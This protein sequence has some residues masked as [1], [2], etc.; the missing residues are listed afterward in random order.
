MRGT[1]DGYN[2]SRIV[3]II[4]QNKLCI[5]M[6][7]LIVYFVIMLGVCFWCGWDWEK[8]YYI[9]QIISGLFVVGGLVVSIL[10]YTASNIANT[11]LRN[12]ERKIRAAEMAN[13]FQKDLIPLMRIIS[14]AYTDS[15]L[16]TTIL[17]K[18]NNAELVMFNKQEI[19]SI[20]SE[21]EKQEMLL[22]LHSAYLAR[23]YVPTK[24]EK[25]SATGKTLSVEYSEK[26]REEASH[27]IR[28][29][30]TKLANSLEYFSMYFNSGI[31]DEN[32]VYQSLHGVFS[33]AL[34]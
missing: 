18:V 24:I 31:A 26:D 4:T 12:Q 16:S 32:T 3:E 15:G 30:L 20:I 11:V 25:D 29:T 7:V 27:T 2:S 19:L 14:T 10:Q 1:K 17:T 9:S 33:G 34:I 8:I 23:N 5:T 28:N 6:I 13:N 21:E 22:K